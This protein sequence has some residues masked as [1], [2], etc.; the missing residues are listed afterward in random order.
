[1]INQ[2]DDELDLE[3]EEDKIKLEIARRQQTTEKQI[4][5]RLRKILRKNEDQLL[6]DDKKFL[7]ARASYL[8]KGQR[9]EY[10][11]IIAA[12]YSGQASQE[13]TVPAEPKLEDLTRPQLDEKAREL[14]IE[15]PEELPNKGAVIEAIKHNQ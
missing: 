5:T 14:G 9:E 8:S 4:V 7:K 10:A 3:Q 11:D 1:M 2:F 6:L 15:K 12:D 13:P